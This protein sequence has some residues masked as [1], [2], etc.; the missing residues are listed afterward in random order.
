MARRLSEYGEQT[1]W[2]EAQFSG[3]ETKSNRQHLWI[4]QGLRSFSRYQF[5]VSFKI[6]PDFP[7]FDSQPSPPV[8][9]LPGGKPSKPTLL[10][11]TQVR[12][13]IR[14]IFGVLGKFLTW[15]IC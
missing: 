4:V 11:I 15:L 6:S 8:R 10:S 12:R 5:K 1:D 9:T 14:T 13:A 3:G 7:G 2:F